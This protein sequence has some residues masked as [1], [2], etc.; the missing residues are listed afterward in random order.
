MKRAVAYLRVS[1]DHQDLGPEAQRAAIAKWAADNGTTIVSWHEDRGVSG[2]TPVDKR[3]GL[4][5]ALRELKKGDVLVAHKRDRLARDVVVAATIE[6]LV[7]KAGSTLVTA[8][9]IGVGDGPE[10]ILLRTIIDAM[11]QYERALIR[12]RICSALAVK[13]ERGEALG[14]V[15]PYGWRRA[16]DQ[17]VEAPDEQAALDLMLNLDAA[18]LP[19]GAI[20]G[21]LESGGH[22][23]RGERWHITSVRRALQRAKKSNNIK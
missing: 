4:L 23:P 15:P 5:A 14:G 22:R 20:V 17:W 8:D 6:S 2:G 12:A 19:L 9:G 1:T 3:P 10:S 18:G 16:G 21:E 7:R 11:A 13:R